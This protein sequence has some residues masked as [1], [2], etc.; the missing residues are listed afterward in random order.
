MR[1]LPVPHLV[2]AAARRAAR[3]ADRLAA[4]RDHD[5]SLPNTEVA[6]L[7]R[8]GLLHAPLPLRL[9]GAA[10][11]LNA[12][13]APVLRD[14]LRIIGGASLPLGRLYE[15]HVN[16][17]RLTARYGDAAMRRCGD[18]A[19]RRCG[20]AAMRRCGAAAQMALLAAE[21]NAGRIS[22]VWNAESPPGLVLTGGRLVGAKRYT[23]GTGMVR[24]PLVT[25]MTPAGMVMAIPDI[26]GAVGDLS[27][28]LPTGIAASATGGTE[29]TGIVVAA[30]EI[31]GAPGDY[32]RTPLFAGGAWRVLAVQLGAVERLVGL[33][34]EAM[35]VRG[36]SG[37]PV[38]RA[39]FGEALARCEAA[40]LWT[41]R[42]AAIAEDPARDAAAVDAF[43]NLARHGFERAALEVIER[44]QRGIGL[45]AM[46]RPS[47]VERIVR[48]LSTYLRQPFPDAALDAASGWSMAA[49]GDMHTDI[50]DY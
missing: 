43:V 5:A 35:N 17:V 19:M 27:E 12:A 4:R 11:G 50:G 32:Y 31:V 37:D 2:P 24:R 22:A 21:C 30:S 23:S 8:Y 20:D 16:A 25:A 1:N 47:P 40:R 29:M 48:D 15:G 36:R 7:H 46:L 41:A 42:A 10:T 26:S 44:V 49:G 9:G 45:S 18:A 28:W 34:R 3:V 38:Q 6:A 13:T 39:R 14:V 33:H